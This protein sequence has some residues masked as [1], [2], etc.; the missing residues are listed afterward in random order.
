MLKA[1]HFFGRAISLWWREWVHLTFLN[2]AWLALQ[3]TI[4][5][6]PP[7]TAAM[8]AVARRLADDEYLELRHY[9]QA[10][11]QMFWPAWRWG[12]VNLVV[13]G[14]IVGNF[15]FYQHT[16]GLLVTLLRVIWATIAIYWFIANLFYWPFWLIQEDHRM[17]TTYRNCLLLLGKKPVLILTISVLCAVLIVASILITLPLAA[18][19]MI[20]LAIIGIVLVKDEVKGISK[21]IQNTD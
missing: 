14:V 21:P 4:V 3:V 1:F 12:A 10:M 16:S 15:W 13:I 20:W 7:A 9:W 8:Y 19:L 6:G 2:I 5:A 18:L 11:R 17:V